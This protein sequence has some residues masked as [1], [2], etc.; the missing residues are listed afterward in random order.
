MDGE[1]GYYEQS[2]TDL[3]SLRDVK[4]ALTWTLLFSL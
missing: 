2:V 1:R 3:L 4:T